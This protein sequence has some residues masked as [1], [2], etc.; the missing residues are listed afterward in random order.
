LP[1][2]RELLVTMMRRAGLAR[3]TPA[4]P[5]STAG[6]CHSVAEAF[7]ERRCSW[8]ERLAADH[9]DPR[10]ILITRANHSYVEAH[11]ADA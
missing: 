6:R 11:D 5:A 8:T 9:P 1:Q 7:I 4:W 10:I 2:S 3:L